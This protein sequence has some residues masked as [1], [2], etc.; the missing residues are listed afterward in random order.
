MEHTV[1]FSVKPALQ[2]SVEKAVRESGQTWAS[3]LFGEEDFPSVGSAESLNA[4]KKPKPTLTAVLKQV[5]SE[6]KRDESRMIN[7]IVHRAV[8]S[9]E[10][11]HEVREQ[12]DE[13][14]VSDLLDHIGAEQKPVKVVRLGKYDQ[15]DLT[16][17]RPLKLV[18]K[19]NDAQEEIMSKAHKV[20]HAPEKFK[21]MSISYDMNKNEQEQC[22]KLVQQA[23]EMS[24]NSTTHK[25]KV[26]GR[27]G[28][29]TLKDFPI[30]QIE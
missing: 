12:N 5:Y 20:V 26:I 29:M 11:S 17:L 30:K 25:W 14:L 15:N 4:P 27:P 13:T 6:H 10:P 8:E 19:N 24:K 16:K 1:E 9:H 18:F 23:K 28:Q 2:Q 22:R 7:V 3:T 21:K